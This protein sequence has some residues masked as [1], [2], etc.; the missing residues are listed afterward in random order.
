VRAITLLADADIDLRGEAGW[1]DEL[2]LE[3]LVARLARLTPA[4]FRARTAPR[5]AR[6]R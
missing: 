6:A 3:V 1:S 4:R 5:R 2:I